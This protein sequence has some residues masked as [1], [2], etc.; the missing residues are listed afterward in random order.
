M[1][2]CLLTL[3]AL[4]LAAGSAHAQPGAAERACVAGDA[5]ACLLFAEQLHKSGDATRVKRAQELYENLCKRRVDQACF[6]LA[7]L[8]DEAND[9]GRARRLYV[10]ACRR[11]HQD[12]CY[13]LAVVQEKEGA[14]GKAYKGYAAVCAKGNLAGCVTLGFHYE[15]GGEELPRDET[16]AAELYR[17]ACDGDDGLGCTSLASM[18]ADGRGVSADLVQA[19]ALHHKSCQSGNMTG[20]TKFGMMLERGQ[21]G[22]ADKSAAESLYV[23]ACEG[24][25]RMA[26]DL[27]QQET[28]K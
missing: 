18:Y 20:C 15:W 26:C 22:T 10:R 24:G 12:A 21:G 13:N 7:V 19:R 25:V 17:Q 11:G 27:K 16:R 6:N 2:L 1:R 5:E 8:Y 3:C 4:V 23:R 28:K 14:V 9:A